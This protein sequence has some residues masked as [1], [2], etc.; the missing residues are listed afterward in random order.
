MTIP[1][2]VREFLS[3]MEGL[4]IAKAGELLDHYGRPEPEPRVRIGDVVMYDGEVWIR[5]MVDDQD[6]WYSPSRDQ[7]KL[8]DFDEVDIEWVIRDGRRVRD[9]LVD[10]EGQEVVQSARELYSA[11][12]WALTQ[13]QLAMLV[14]KPGGRGMLMAPVKG[15]RDANT[16][17]M[18]WR[19]ELA[20]V[21]DDE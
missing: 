4:G 13:W 10:G 15:I 16:L 11:V 5:D 1:I 21:P 14:P 8:G 18:A 9:Q 3:Q 6:C 12:E 17:V 7:T 2:P 20:K 19:E